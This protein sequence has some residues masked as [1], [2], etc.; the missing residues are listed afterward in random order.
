MKTTV[1]RF[2]A[3]TSLVFKRFKL[4]WM[5]NVRCLD[6]IKNSLA[7]TVRNKRTKRTDFRNQA[8]GFNMVT[9]SKNVD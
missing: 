1:K 4:V 9:V 5:L 3:G 6:A 2:N 8:F 7:L